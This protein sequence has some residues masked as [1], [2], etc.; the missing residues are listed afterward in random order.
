MV[1]RALSTHVSADLEGKMVFLSG[2]RQSGKT[3]L[4]RALLSKQH[5]AFA[6]RYLNWDDDEARTRVLNREFP[7]D[8]LVVFDELHKYSRWRNFL[9]GIYDTR[10]GPAHPRDRERTPRPLSPGR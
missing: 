9:K 2:P 8:G 3:T 7:H 5:R 10:A 6:S 1:A 4:A